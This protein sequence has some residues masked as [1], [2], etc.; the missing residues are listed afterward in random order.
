MKSNNRKSV[1][2]KSRRSLS[3]GRLEQRNLL[4]GVTL[5]GATG[6]LTIF[7]DSGNNVATA[8]ESGSQIRVT[9]ND[10]GDHNFASSQVSE[11]V[12]IGFAGD[13]VYVNNTA[14]PARIF[15]HSGSDTLTGGSADDLIVGGRGDDVLRGAAGNDTIIGAFG[16]DEARGGAGDDSLFGSAGLNTLYGDAGNDTIFGGDEVDNIFGNDGADQIFGLGG[17]DI[18]DSGAGGVAGSTGFA[19][20]DLVLGLDG[21]DTIRGGGGLDVFWG[22][23]GNDTLI[24]GNGENRLHGQNGDDTISGGTQADFLRGLAGNDTINGG[25]GNDYV[26]LGTGSADVAVFDRAFANYSVDTT[27]RGQSATVRSGSV[28]DTVFGTELIQFSDRQISS[29]QA[30]LAAAEQRSFELLNARRSAINIPTFSHPQDA[31][32]YAENWARNMSVNGLRHSS[33]ADLRTLVVNGRTTFGENIIFIQD[34]GQSADAIATEMHDLWMGSPT[35]RNNI[36]NSAF[37]EVGVGIVQANGGWWG[38]HVFYG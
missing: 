31:T 2:S 14:K 24:G 19:Q 21:N 36:Q 9:T 3:Y 38:V 27:N 12:F 16:N 32:T 34:I 25:G 10:A 18:I 29:N 37:T 20:A 26:D 6:E 35:H 13:D 23:E 15:G 8:T 4:A 22:G 33:S 28:T 5:D 1:R 11:I 30:T 7:G 17:D